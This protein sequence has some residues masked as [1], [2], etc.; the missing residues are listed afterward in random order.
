MEFFSQ[1]VINFF[2]QHFLSENVI[3]SEQS[4][5]WEYVNYDKLGGRASE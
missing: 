2:L 5:L 4:N 3:S 1:L